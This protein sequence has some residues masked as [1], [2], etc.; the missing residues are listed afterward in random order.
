MTSGLLV[1]SSTIRAVTVARASLLSRLP[2]FFDQMTLAVGR[3]ANASRGDGGR[4]LGGAPCCCFPGAATNGAPLTTQ[5]AR[6]TASEKTSFE[7]FRIY[8][9]RGG[10]TTTPSVSRKYPSFE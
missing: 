4:S 5:P 2:I 1:V 6:Q 7:I 9:L 8:I 3:E 10:I